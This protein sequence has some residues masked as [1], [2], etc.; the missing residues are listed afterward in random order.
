MSLTGV[1]MN[2][3]KSIMVLN[4]HSDGT[5][6]GKYRSL[7]GRDPHTRNLAG[8]ASADENGKQILGFVVC[9]QIDN[10]SSGYGHFSVC[11]WSG[12]IRNSEIKTHWL[13]TISLLKE[14]DEWSSTLVGEDEFEK[15][16]D[17]PE[18]EHLQANIAALKN[19]LAQARTSRSRS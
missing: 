10:P 7:V 17:V 3:L 5:L 2:E 8:M 9:F 19:L 14:V 11:T 4:E 1:W 13:L 6:T 15:V 18:E 16:S 12:W